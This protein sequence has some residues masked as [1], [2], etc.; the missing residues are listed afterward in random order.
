M[1][2]LNEKDIHQ[3]LKPAELVQHMELAFKS[4]HREDYIMP[5]RMH[6][7]MGKSNTLLLMPSASGDNFCTKLVSVFPDNA[8]HGKPAIYGSLIFND[9]TSGEPL[10]IMNGAALTA[11]R[12]GA[13]GALAAQ[14]TTPGNPAAL[15]IIGAGTQGVYQA[16]MISSVLPITKVYVCDQIPEQVQ[17]FIDRLRLLKPDIEVEASKD[18]KQLLAACEIIVTASSSRTAVLPNNASLL[19]GKHFI[20]IGSYRKDM[21]ELPKAIFKLI[22]QYFIDAPSARHESGDVIHPVKEK[23]ISG[24]NIYTLSEL[25]TGQ[26]IIDRSRTTL[27]KSVGMSL[28]DLF[29]AKLAYRNAIRFNIGTNIEI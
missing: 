11:L 16:F 20:A 28:F 27:V 17:L 3:A 2:I 6:M 1:Q 12:T 7:D 18:S 22:Q 24:R 23:W 10:A 25:I 14:Y 26:T 8:K 13:V 19:E 9:G 4:F 29:A 15:G 21:Q 5:D